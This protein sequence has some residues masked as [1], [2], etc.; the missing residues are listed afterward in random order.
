MT[1]SNTIRMKDLAKK[2]GVSIATVSRVLSDSDGS[3]PEMRE[4]VRKL[5]R[6]NGYKRLRRKPVRRQD[7]DRKNVNGRIALIAAEY[8]NPRFLDAS[9][10]YM[11]M[12]NSIHALA[13]EAG[14][15][16]VIDW[17][18]GA[19][20]LSLPNSVRRGNVDGALLTGYM[21]DELIS[22]I[23]GRIPTV[24]IGGI[25]YWVDV[26]CYI[27]HSQKSIA[28]AVRHLAEMGHTTIGYLNPFEQRESTMSSCRSLLYL[29]ESREVFERSVK[30]LGLCDAPELSAALPLN[31]DSQLSDVVSQCLTN[32][33]QRSQR[34]TAM[35]IPIAAAGFVLQD[36]S[37][38]GLRVPQDVSLLVSGD[39][40]QAE[41][42]RPPL[43]TID[44]D[45]A[46]MAK[47]A[48]AAL[49]DGISGKPIETQ[50]IMFDPVFHQR[51]S[52]APP[53]GNLAKA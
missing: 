11:S 20:D 23:A 51:E 9:Y 30:R 21:P 32:W 50:T 1:A 16:V 46:K 3:S 45:R 12:V 42:M 22:K 8:L 26:P 4:R 28:V 41:H 52:I 39:A 48:M 25:T 13:N 35:I 10:T 2:A 53:R 27:G 5:A 14:W 6:E 34:V 17:A 7:V 47:C 18:G 38:R 36:L 24:L 29:R 49:M 40:A 37:F 15:E 19:G 44:F 43:S 33:L 31:E